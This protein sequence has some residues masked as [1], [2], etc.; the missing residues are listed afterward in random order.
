MK[1][2]INQKF[3]DIRKKLAQVTTLASLGILVVGLIFAFKRDMQS[4]TISYIALI[5]GFILSQVGMYFT[6][7]FDRSPRLD[8]VLTKAFENLRHEYTFFVYTSPKPLV[9]TGPC[10][11][12]LIMPITAN[13]LISFENGKW[14]QKGGNFLLKTLG[15]EGIGNPS[16]EAEVNTDELRKYLISKGIPQEELPQITPIL[17]VMM[18]TT[19]LG[20][21]SG[22]GMVITDL[23][24]VKRY[25]RRVDREACATP[26]DQEKRDRINAALLQ[27]AKN[28]V[29]ISEDVKA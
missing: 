13:G 12:W 26:M 18:K 25:I 19:Q 22:S 1:L 5:A 29:T 15:Q 8:Q 11:I 6:S 4:V 7:R 2:V 17:V 16:R 24:E 21:V 10:G 14:K 28:Q 3:I 9:L 20:D 27:N 23:S